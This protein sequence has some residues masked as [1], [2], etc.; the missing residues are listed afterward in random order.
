MY[1][2]SLQWEYGVGWFIIADQLSIIIS[3]SYEDNSDNSNN[4][5]IKIIVPPDITSHWRDRR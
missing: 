5:V 1:Y 4:F 2:S 3:N